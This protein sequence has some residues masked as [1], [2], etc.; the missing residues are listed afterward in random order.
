MV[1]PIYSWGLLTEPKDVLGGA[2]VSQFFLV[3][4]VSTSPHLTDL[5]YNLRAGARLSVFLFAIV[6]DLA[7]HIFTKNEEDIS[8][9]MDVIFMPL[10]WLH[11][12]TD[13]LIGI[14]KLFYTSILPGTKKTLYFSII[15]KVGC[16]SK[17]VLFLVDKLKDFV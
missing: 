10:G 2:T 3:F 6:S 4:V 1:Q 9:V 7:V 13:K 8:G 15:T 16:V 12:N 17:L 5:D 11:R 14:S